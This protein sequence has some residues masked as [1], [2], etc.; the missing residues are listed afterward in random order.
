MSPGTI[1]I[2]KKMSTA[3]PRSVGIISTSRLTMYLLTP[4]RPLL[5][6]PHA[7]E[8]ADDLRA[9]SV[10][11]IEAEHGDVDTS[12]RVDQ[13]ERPLTVAVGGGGLGRDDVEK[14]AAEGRTLL[15]VR[16]AAGRRKQHHAGEAGDC[17]TT[18]RCRTGASWAHRALTR[19]ARRCRAA[20]SGSGSA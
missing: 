19:S 14:L 8:L 15:G 20:G 10:G 6:E 4:V 1:R 11:R 3:T 18:K 12:Q 17:E 5:G 7:V 16:T 2:R 9:S 13:R